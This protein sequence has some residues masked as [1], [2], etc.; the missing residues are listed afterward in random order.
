M[1]LRGCDLN[2]VITYPTAPTERGKMI[3][4]VP[5]FNPSV[6]LVIDTIPKGGYTRRY[7]QGMELEY[8]Y[9]GS[10]VIRGQC[11]TPRLEWEIQCHLSPQGRSLLWAIAEYSDT[12]RRTHPRTGYEITCDDIMRSLIE[13][14][15]TRAK[16]ATTEPYQVI[17]GQRIEYFPRCNV[18]IPIPEIKEENLGNGY[19]LGFK[20]QEV[21]LTSPS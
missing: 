6:A 20:M 13:L 8:S 7:V 18:I 11:F 16:A 12:K 9:N 3:L 10:A 2:N 17:F 15:R 19:K 5:G 21:A 4:Y 14:N 1:A